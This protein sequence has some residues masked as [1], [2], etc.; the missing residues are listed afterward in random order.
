MIRFLSAMNVVIIICRFPCNFD[1]NIKI[2]NLWFWCFTIATKCINGIITAILIININDLINHCN[3]FNPARAEKMREHLYPAVNKHP[4]H[5]SWRLQGCES[6]GL[7]S[8][9]LDFLKKN[10]SGIMPKL[11]NT[12]L[13]VHPWTARASWAPISC[14]RTRS[15]AFGPPMKP[16]LPKTSHDIFAAK[17]SKSFCAPPLQA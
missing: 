9:W 5:T 13:V 8:E 14:A 15:I 10:S 7:L 4:L 16:K 12:K 6:Q 3:V 2:F 17:L 11:F 1:Y